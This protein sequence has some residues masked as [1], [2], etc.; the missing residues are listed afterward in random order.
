LTPSEPT[1]KAKTAKCDRCGAPRARAAKFCGTC[2]AASREH[3]TATRAQWSDSAKVDRRH[4]RAVASVFVGTLGGM[5]LLALVLGEEGSETQY[6]L[7]A[8]AA[9]LVAGF[10]ALALL[11]KGAWRASLAGPAS[12]R[13]LALALPIGAL[14]F[15]ASF[16]WVESVWVESIFPGAPEFD[17]LAPGLP[18]LL[19]GATLVPIVEEW[20]DRGVL[21][22]ALA[23]LTGRAGQIVLTAM[24]FALL[25][26]LNGGFV[27]ELPHRFAGGLLL[28]WLRARSGSL[29]PS[30]VAHVTW[31]ALA[32]AVD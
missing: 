7:A 29:L 30:I 4:S 31:N 17:E 11:G 10:T 32:A 14:G 5:L 15:A 20:L 9:Q 13:D 8:L 6:L 12:V 19:L 23:P 24:L 1:P 21:W 28:G 16:V 25:H 26:G 27:L 22:N 3:K 2:G 18:L